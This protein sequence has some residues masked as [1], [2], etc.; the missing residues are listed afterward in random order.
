MCDRLK[1][2]A[3]VLHE[4]SLKRP[5][6]TFNALS[7][8][9]VDLDQP[10][11]TE[12][13]VRVV[14]AG[15]CHSDL[16]AIR[17]VRKVPLPIVLGHECS[18]VVEE[19]GKNVQTVKSGDHVVM[20][21]VPSCGKCE[22]CARGLPSLCDFGRASNREGQLLAGG[23]RFHAEG[24]RM[25]HHLG[26]S[27]FAEH[28][29]VSELSVIPVPRAIPLEKVALF[30]C[31]VLTG[32]GSVINRGD[33]KAGRSV[34]VF[35][36][37]GVGLNVIQGARLVGASQV[38]AVD[39]ASSK[40]AL[41]KK[42]G[43]TDTIDASSEDPIDSIKEMTDGR[44]VDYAFEASGNTEVMN[45]AFMSTRKGG[46]T[47][48]IGITSPEDRLNIPS[49]VLVDE[50]R[51]L[52][53]SFMGSVIPRRDI[54]RLIDLYMKGLIKLDDLITRYI[55]LDEINDG[56]E[57]LASGEAARQIIRMS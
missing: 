46:D 42:F 11:E 8:E 33:V 41:A 50:Q 53:G 56:F 22:F 57:A 36:C 18:G 55:S 30:G 48:L 34:A 7:V 15:I 13:L 1:I 3:S 54:P 35:G 23:T 21:Y 32:I 39:V 16:A 12:V 4:I 24:R 37:G 26:V 9:E 5:Y 49:S 45:Q 38:I 17:G 44:G 27:A 51:Q 40:L 19:V 31:A 10:K 25:F 14:G 52:K 47:I 28:T 29:V 6:T 20:T 2:R 43:A